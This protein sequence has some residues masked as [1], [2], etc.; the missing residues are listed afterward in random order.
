MD[1]EEVSVACMC[2]NRSCPCCWCPDSQLD[3][4]HNT[5]EYR[6]AADVSAQVEVARDELLDDD[7]NVLRGK[8]DDVPPVPM[9][10]S[11]LLRDRNFNVACESG[12]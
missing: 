2:S 5:C 12:I 3:E 7:E 11:A 10:K 1:G 4:A 6:K 9:P 8:G